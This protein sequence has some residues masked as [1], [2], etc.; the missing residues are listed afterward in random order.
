MEG[1]PESLR[2]G[3][4]WDGHSPLNSSHYDDGQG[5]KE[6]DQGTVP[7]ARSK[8]VTAQGAQ[9]RNLQVI[10]TQEAQSL[11]GTPTPGVIN[12]KIKKMEEYILEQ[13][14]H[15]DQP[16]KDLESTF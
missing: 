1:I 15:M 12:K 3:V 14:K 4:N 5:S 8:N 7:F 13:T 11:S 9:E 6:W 16:K 2:V 10:S